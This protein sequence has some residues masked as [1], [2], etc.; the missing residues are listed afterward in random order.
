MIE[1]TNLRIMERFSDNLYNRIAN[2]YGCNNY[3]L[4]KEDGG[5]WLMAV[6]GLHKLAAG[7]PLLHGR[8]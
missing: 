8:L 5:K 4:A 7:R 2:V 6:K 1:E 3:I